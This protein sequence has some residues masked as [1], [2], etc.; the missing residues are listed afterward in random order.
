MAVVRLTLMRAMGGGTE[1]RTGTVD[2]KITLP[3]GRSMREALAE[4]V[5]HCREERDHCDE[6]GRSSRAECFERI[7]VAIEELPAPREAAHYPNGMGEESRRLHRE[8]NKLV[9][10]QRRGEMN[11]YQVRELTD[12]CAAKGIIL[13]PHGEDL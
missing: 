9:E 5:Q 11:G 2:I 6:N 3:D 4:L 8:Y 7:A 12:E 13:V 1:E 10:A